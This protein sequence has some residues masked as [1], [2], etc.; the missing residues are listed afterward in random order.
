ML[1]RSSRLTGSVVRATG[2]VGGCSALGLQRRAVHRPGVA[3]DVVLGDQALGPDR[4]R[5]VLVE[6]QEPAVDRGLDPSLE[7]RGHDD[8]VDRP[9]LGA[10]DLHQLAADQP[11]GVVEDH[12]EAR[13]SSSP[14]RSAPSTISTAADRRRQVRRRSPA[15]RLTGAG[16]RPD[17]RVPLPGTSGRRPW[18][19]VVRRGLRPPP[20]HGAISPVRAPLSGPSALVALPSRLSSPVSD[21]PAG[22]NGEHGLEVVAVGVVGAAGRAADAVEEPADEVRGVRAQ[23][24]EDRGDSAERGGERVHRRGRRLLRPGADASS[25]ASALGRAPGSRRS[26]GPRCAPPGPAPASRVASRGATGC[27]SVS[28]RVEAMQ[29]V[30]DVGEHP[31]APARA[32]P[33][34]RV[35]MSASAARSARDLAQ[36]RRGV[37]DRPG[38]V[39]VACGESR[40][41]RRS[42]GDQAR[43]RVAVGDDLTCE[44]SGLAERRV[45]VDRAP[46]ELRC[47]RLSEEVCPG[48]EDLLQRGP[49]L[50][51]ERVEHDVEVDD[52]RVCVAGSVPPLGIARPAPERVSPTNRLATPVRLS[53]PIVA[54]L[55][56]VDGRDAGI[57]DVELDVGEA[58]VGQP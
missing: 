36:R 20:G 35:S 54:T 9:R 51:G 56:G 53:C 16:R 14:G 39:P 33:G 15:S 2:T 21:A 52:P 40:G 58:V 25:A 26:S 49:D 10:G 30:V 7:V 55:A 42:R 27:R 3:V 47:G 6:G 12:V 57:G 13:R 46:V 1:N 34:A 48:L 31:R 28:S 44:P 38:E 4:A 19:R 23:A 43:E 41:E 17:C 45:E 5:R 50:G 11:A 37:R 29:R 8:V 24:G 18:V 32:P 22:L